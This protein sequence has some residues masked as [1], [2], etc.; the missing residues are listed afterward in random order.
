MNRQASRV[1]AISSGQKAVL[2]PGLSL[3]LAY[4]LFSLSACEPFPS[5]APT[6][7]PAP[8]KTSTPVSPTETAIPTPSLPPPSPPVTYNQAF[9]EALG[10]DPE[11]CLPDKTSSFVGVYIYDLDEER[12]LVS[13][14][15]DMP[16][17]FASAFKSPVLTY[18][19][20]S[21][22]KIWD[23]NNPAWEI[24]A[25]ETA[26]GHES[27]WYQS[28]E[29]RQKLADQIYNSGGW[30]E[31]ETFS[32]ENR[33]VVDGEAGP[34][35]KR[36]FILH[37]VYNMVTESNNISAGD[38]LNFVFDNCLELEDN[39]EAACGGPNALTGFNAWFNRFA[40]I[41][42]PMNEPQR[43][44]YNWD[45]LQ[46][47]DEEGKLQEL[48]MPTAG[49]KDSCVTARASLSCVSDQTAVNAY[50]PRDLF[51]FYYALY[52][53][54][55]NRVRKTSLDILGVPP[56]GISRGYL[57]NLASTLGVRSMSKNGRAA[58]SGKAIVT[59]AGILSYGGKSYVIVTLSYNAVEAMERLYGCY[60]ESGTL[61]HEEKCLIMSLL[62]GELRPDEE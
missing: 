19:L 43:G 3:A 13:I 41:E 37:Q 45:T 25:L 36:Y 52:H 26:P 28:R 14:N 61:V 40:G 22:Q 51:L 47:R 48:E 56:T 53:L 4:L 7:G 12:E 9:L 20:E 5:A 1:R 62:D 2:I 60:L 42:V 58:Y 34:L 33:P 27:N 35:D 46:M 38:V 11:S 16:F 55:E 10:T 23:P 31:I 21:C 59:D 15:A 50:T 17:Q 54:P 49:Q 30:G 6:P 8:T 29:Y 57:K 32:F 24:H 18:F 39:N 44:L